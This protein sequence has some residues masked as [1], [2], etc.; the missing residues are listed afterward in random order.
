ME[1]NKCSAHI[2]DEQNVKLKHR[3]IFFPPTQQ[4]IKKAIREQK[5][6]Q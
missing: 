4:K 5:Y 1:Q 6:V 3:N 2:T